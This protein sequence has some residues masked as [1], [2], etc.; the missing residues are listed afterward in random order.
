M[1]FSLQQTRIDK[2]LKQRNYGMIVNV[3]LFGLCLI[4][5]FVVLM[6][7]GKQRLIVVPAN[8]ESDVWLDDKN[9]SPSYLAQ[10]SEFYA[11]LRFNI[12]PLNA[13]KQ[14]ALL[15]RHVAPSVYGEVSAQLAD[16]LDRIQKHHISTVFYPIDTQVDAKKFI[17]QIKGE[18][19]RTVG[20]ESMPVKRVTY[21]IKYHYR[22]G[23]L[24]V[25]E[26]KEIK[27]EK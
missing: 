1:E 11:L 7:Q 21:Q 24:L 8:L 27:N 9:V 13:K 12:T 22:H 18:L 20:R 17:V 23:R 10:M 26:F 16:E 25:M 14:H 15:L 19:A 5:S 4:L 2:L 3:G 6:G